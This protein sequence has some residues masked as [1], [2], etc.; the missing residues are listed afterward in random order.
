MRHPPKID[1]C[2]SNLNLVNELHSLKGNEND[3]GSIN[4]HGE[5]PVPHR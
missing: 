2:T 1:L 4:Q 3:Y 5:C